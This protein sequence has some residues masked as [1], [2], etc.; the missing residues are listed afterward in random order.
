MYISF[1]LLS[2]Q[3]MLPLLS[4]LHC[5]LL[6][7]FSMYNGND[8]FV[9]FVP[10]LVFV[11]HL[12]VKMVKK[13]CNKEILKNIIFLFFS[14]T[15]V[16]TML[17]SS[18]HNFVT[19]SN[20]LHSIGTAGWFST[21]LYFSKETSFLGEKPHHGPEFETPLHMPSHP[22]HTSTL[23]PTHHPK[24]PLRNFHRHASFQT[25][26]QGYLKKTTTT[27]VCTWLI[28]CGCKTPFF[29]HQK[30]QDVHF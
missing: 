10:F 13:C 25:F 8:H 5:S 23:P 1:F 4:L 6:I 3:W 7:F 27:N 19:W 30:P 14:S 29:F 21:W 17:F 20:K 16:S 9:T 22:I 2:L 11:I 26:Y 28:R 18:C 24:D 15:S 12:D